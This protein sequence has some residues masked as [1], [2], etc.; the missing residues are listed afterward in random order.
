LA[1]EAQIVKKKLVN[2]SNLYTL[3]Y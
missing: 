2:C 1:F 3:W